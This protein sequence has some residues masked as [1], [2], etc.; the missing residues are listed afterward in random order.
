[1]TPYSGS[2]CSF[3]TVPAPVRSLN[4]TQNDPIVGHFG[5][6]ILLAGCKMPG[7]GIVEKIVDSCD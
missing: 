6:K 4:N 3:V 1:M 7:I 2:F 5:A